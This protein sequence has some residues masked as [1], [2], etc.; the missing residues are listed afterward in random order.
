VYAKEWGSHKGPHFILRQEW[1]VAI[2]DW[3]G[4]RLGQ[5]WYPP[6]GLVIRCPLGVL[7]WSNTITSWAV[8]LCRP[9]CWLEWRG[10]HPLTA[11]RHTM[12][13]T[14]A[15]CLSRVYPGSAPFHNTITGA[16]LIPYAAGI[17][18]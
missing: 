5:E 7:V 8:G 10:T 15:I 6:N 2:L 13:A 12:P 18:P 17:L 16:I 1:M 11:P 14:V 9:N 3:G 4:H